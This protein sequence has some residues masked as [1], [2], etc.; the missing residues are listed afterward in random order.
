MWSIAYCSDEIWTLRKIDHKFLESFEMCVCKRMEKI[1]WTDLMKNEILRRVKE[2]GNTLYTTL[3]R[4]ANWKV[5]S[6]IGHAV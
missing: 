2:E 5:T 1:S 3:E 6:C 4:K